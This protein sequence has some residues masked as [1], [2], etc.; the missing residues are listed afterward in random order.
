M[1]QSVLK[2]IKNNKEKVIFTG[3]MLLVILLL[4][5]DIFEYGIFYDEVNRYNP[6]FPIFN[7][8]AGE[9][10]QAIWSIQIFGRTIPMMYKEYISSMKTFW[11]L[12]ILLFKNP[13]LGIRIWYIIC[14]IIEMMM[15]F[16]FLYRYDAKFALAVS[17]LVMVN[18]LL[19]PDFNYG[20]AYLIHFIF[21]IGG[22][23]FI[24]KYL[25]KEKNIYLFLSMFIFALGANISFYFIWTLAAMIVAS[26]VLNHDIWFGIFK[27]VKSL[28]CA[29]LGVFLG[30]FQFVLYNILNGFPTVKVFLKNIFDHSN[31]EM[32]AVKQET[33]GEGLL[34]VIKS[35]NKLLN[36]M[37]AFYIVIMILLLVVWIFLAVKRKQFNIQKYYYYPILVLFLSLLFI[38]ISPKPRFA[39][40]LLHLSP[41]FEISLILGMVCLFKNKKIN[42]LLFVGF[43]LFSLINSE[44]KVE[45]RKTAV[46]TQNISSD[47]F[48]LT[49]YFENNDVISQ[50]IWFLEWG[51]EA[52]VYFLTKGEISDQQ[53]DYYA[54]LDMN[55]D[56]CKDFIYNSLLYDRNAETYVPLYTHT[57]TG[58][59]YDKVK[60]AFLDVLQEY[61]I[62]NE[63]II[64]SEKAEDIELYFIDASNLEFSTDILIDRENII[65]TSDYNYAVESREQSGETQI[66]KGW[67]YLNSSEIDTI[68]ICNEDYQVIGFCDYGIERSDVY[69]AYGKGYKSGFNMKL[70]SDENYKIIAVSVDGVRYELMNFN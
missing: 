31:F 55:Y 30:M 12:P 27:K 28:I 32:D 63:R 57:N 4:M 26:L 39:Y 16:S 52:P 36:G 41:W 47:I 22:I 23:Y 38:L 48:D 40:H 18:P 43:M 50:D 69:A 13:M 58:L 49:D 7:K 61:K 25:S 44:I 46:N 34:T 6:I 17:V 64:Y 9:N 8:S 3:V 11:I 10:E 33:F 51:L 20:F 1:Y 60:S 68:L 66:I 54:L 21:L 45:K 24:Q 15:L 65:E 53:K 67:L 29:I 2:F 70:K 62:P 19:Y 59:G 14:F 56:D 5:R 35:W 37:L 42:Y